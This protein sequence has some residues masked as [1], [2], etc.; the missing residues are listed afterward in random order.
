VEAGCASS[1]QP[2]R[3]YNFALIDPVDQ[4][5]ATF[6]YFYRTWEQLRDLGPLSDGRQSAGEENDMSVIEPDEESIA[7]DEA[8]GA[9]RA[10]DRETEDVVH[11][12][13]D[14]A[15]DPRAHDAPIADSEQ[16]RWSSIRCVAG[17]AQT[18]RPLPATPRQLT[19]NGIA[20]PPLEKRKGQGLRA[21][22]LLNVISSTWTRLG[23]RP[24]G[25]DSHGGAGS[26]SGAR[27]VS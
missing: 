6:K 24:A 2:K 11:D 23:T 20:T 16:K 7:G 3:F 13:G 21:A 5:F 15:V 17:Q 18:V 22:S 26:R 25:T 27:S 8:R 4:P 19:R 1:E 10:S 12:C 14:G 9:A